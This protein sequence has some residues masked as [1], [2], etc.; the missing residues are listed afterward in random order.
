MSKEHAWP[1]WL[2]KLLRT[3]SKQTVNIKAEIDGGRPWTNWHG[4]KGSI[5]VAGICKNCNGGW[6]S[7][8][9]QEA[10]PILEP[11]IRNTESTLDSRQQLI[12]A[13]WVVKTSM[14]FDIHRSPDN[15]FYQP[16]QTSHLFNNQTPP[17]STFGLWIGRYYGENNA[18]T[19]GKTLNGFDTKAG[20]PIKGHVQTMTFGPLVTQVLNV[21]MPKGQTI[22]SPITLD[23]V[24]GEWIQATIRLWPIE[25][26]PLYWPPTLSL[27]D[28]QGGLY[29]FAN[30]FNVTTPPA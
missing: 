25:L 30:R 24:P 21:R 16:V 8:L 2:L 17:P 6:M 12:I 11:L 15:P 4:P 27:N 10:K 13:T 28:T 22:T 9:E 14:V 23:T 18:F 29:T 20:R 3:L 7:E 26:K 19:D 5:R 1:N